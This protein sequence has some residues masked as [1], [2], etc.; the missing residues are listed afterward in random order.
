MFSHS[1]QSMGTFLL[2]L[3]RTRHI[4][5]LGHLHWLECLAFFQIFILSIFISSLHE[6]HHHI[7]ANIVQIATRSLLPFHTLLIFFIVLTVYTHCVCV[8]V[9]YMCV[10]V[11]VYVCGVHMFILLF[12]KHLYSAW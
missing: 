10:C 5:I 11:Y 2:L 7:E 3:N 8:Y 9:F 1:V 4:L 12:S 6:C